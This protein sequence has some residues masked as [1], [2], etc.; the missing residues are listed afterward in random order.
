MLLELISLPLV[1]LLPLC[2]FHFHGFCGDAFS[3]T[4][5][6]G[7]CTQLGIYAF[8]FWPMSFVKQEVR[9]A[10]SDHLLKCVEHL[11]AGPGPLWLGCHSVFYHC[12]LLLTW[13]GWH[14]GF[15]CVT[16]LFA[17]TAFPL[18]TCAAREFLSPSGH[19]RGDRIF[20]VISRLMAKWSAN[21]QCSAVQCSILEWTL[22]ISNTTLVSSNK[23]NNKNN[24]PYAYTNTHSITP[25][26]IAH[27]HYCT[28]CYCNC[29]ADREH[30]PVLQVNRS[31]E[32]GSIEVDDSRRTRTDLQSAFSHH[33]A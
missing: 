23:S 16:A 18:W 11:A 10:A 2:C 8:P 26:Y 24:R 32:V 6:G 22:K 4:S 5:A 21:H 7:V 1:L 33:L 19:N 14:R 3:W 17:C 25:W 20:M 31:V 30:W 28:G 15:G 13:S 27:V 29:V 9:K 12:S